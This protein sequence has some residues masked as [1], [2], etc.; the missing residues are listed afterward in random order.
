M[1]YTNDTRM[2]R[3]S[4]RALA[5]IAAFA[6]SVPALAQQKTGPGISGEDSLTWHG[7][8][9]YGIVDIGLQYDS[10]GAP[11]SD[12]FPGGSA[13]VVAKNSNNSV[14]GITPSNLTQSRVGLQGKED[15]HFMDWSAVFKLET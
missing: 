15:L 2:A 12:Y 11:I 4:R 1:N 10:H 13:D 9:L 5:L 6:A 7:I 3:R 8:T 14:S